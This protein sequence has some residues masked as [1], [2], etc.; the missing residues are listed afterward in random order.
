IAMAIVLGVGTPASANPRYD[1]WQAQHP[2]VLAA[3]ATHPA[4]GGG[5]LDLDYF[6]N[7]GLNTA[8]DG[9][10]AYNAQRPMPDLKGLPIIY[11][12]YMNRMPDLD[13]FI[14]DFGKARQHHEN[15]VIVLLGDEVKSSHGEGGLTHMRQ[16]RDWV[17]NNED[18]EISSLLTMTCVPAAGKVS[19]S[20]AIQEYYDDTWQR[21]QPDV[22]LPQFYPSRNGNTMGGAFY[23]GLEW[24]FN[25]AKERDVALWSCNR[26]WTS[27]PPLPSESLLR[28]QRYANLAYGVTGMVDFLWVADS[29]PTIKDGG[30]WNI[31]GP[32]P[33]VLYKRL[34]PINR[35]I[36]RLGPTMLKL[37]P[38]R[39]YHMDGRDDG[40]GVHHWSDVDGDLPSWMCRSGLLANVTGASNR[41]HVMVGFFRDDAGQ[42]YFMVVNKDIGPGTGVEVATDIQLT[43]HPSV[44]GLQRLNRITGQV[45]DIAVEGGN[46]LFSLAGGTG[47]LFKFDNGTGFA[48][49]EEVV[50]PRLVSAKP[51]GGGSVP[52]L[53]N[54]PLRFT[55]DRDATQ[56]RAEIREVGENGELLAEDLAAKFTR[57][58]SEDKRAITYGENGSALKDG[59][60]YRVILHWAQAVA[61]TLYAVRGDVNGD[62][63]R[64]AAD[65]E[66]VQAQAGSADAF[67][68][69]DVNGDGV[70][71]ENDYQLIDRLVNIPQVSWS[72]SFEGYSEG[73]LAGQGGWL[74]PQTL[75]GTVLN[76]AWVNGSAVVSSEAGP[77]D[78]A[79]KATSAGGYFWGNEIQFNQSGGVGAVGV[80]KFG[81]LTRLREKGYQNVGVHL[82]NSS[83]TAGQLGQF[84]VEVMGGAY[85]QAA[86]IR[87]GR[88]IVLGE[89]T[90]SVA[91][92][93]GLGPD[94][95][96]LAVDVVVDFGANILTWQCR[97]R[98]DDK[99]YG[100]FTVLFEGT[101]LGLDAMDFVVRD[102]GCELDNIYIRN[103]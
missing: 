20:S 33:T 95:K 71:D 32:N 42:E 100:P 6:L 55:F 99:L 81:F 7:A 78:G 9:R 44:T 63:Q 5:E 1:A 72:E 30:Y 73:P 41:N 96:G 84:T 82:W 90:K 27:G 37:T 86:L 83:D 18:P 17:V 39:A 22:L 15:I 23:S 75:P 4:G 52:R 67:S 31:T 98:D 61:M 47:D 58:L 34:A 70:V 69:A 49:I 74:E 3:W 8:F 12:V 89:G 51:A 11:M 97:N 29:S 26:A 65:M 87:A 2:F 80:L 62:K 66:L 92:A 45:E 19:S 102:P 54:N 24:C 36:A 64:T 93:G 21:I 57:D 43:F 48:G 53:M 40:D 25:F 76:R 101:A 35:E 38:V 10:C 85:S 94:S 46:C 77:L 88:G 91:L 59:C 13:G 28:M 79:H 56:V 60:E 16:I 50:P 68:R 103:F 14:A